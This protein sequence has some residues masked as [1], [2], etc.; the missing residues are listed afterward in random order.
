MPLA[1]LFRPSAEISDAE[2]ARVFALISGP[3]VSDTPPAP[4]FRAPALRIQQGSAREP[5]HAVPGSPVRCWIDGRVFDVARAA[6][7]HGFPEAATASA[8]L[9]QAW[10]RGRLDQVLPDLNGDFFAALHDER[11]GKLVLIADR[12]GLR[13]VYFRARAPEFFFCSRLRGFLGLANFSPRIAEETAACF[14]DLGHLAGD[15][16]WFEGVNLLPP[17]TWLEV[18]LNA[19]SPPRLRRYWTWQAI[20]PLNLEL[21]EAVE[22]FSRLLRQA[23]SRR[24][25]PGEKVSVLLSGGLDSRALLGCV[26]PASLGGTATFGQP[27]C[28]DVVYAERVARIYGSDHA[29]FP[30]TPENWDRGRFHAVWKCDGMSSPADLSSSQFSGEMAALGAA[31]M[32]GFAGDLVAG[33]SYLK[34]GFLNTAA[35]A[36]FAA[37]SYGEQ[38]RWTD[39]GDD[40]ARGPHTDPFVLANRVRRLT[41]AGNLE[42]DDRVEQRKPF[43]DVDLLDFLYAL[44]DEYRWKGKLYHRA[45]LRMRPDL[46]GGVP[47]QKTGLP[48]SAGEGPLGWARA[49]RIRLWEKLG[50]NRMPGEFQ[51]FPRWLAASAPRYAALLGNK[52]A[53]WPGFVDEGRR[54]N[55]DWKNRLAGGNVRTLLHAIGLEVWLQQVFNGRYRDPGASA[56]EA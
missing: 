19:G 23:V 33:G 35:D 38:A 34:A 1:G 56:T 8:L 32:N 48:L 25:F 6:R 20:R 54:E 21:P 46:F 41:V 10:E 26:P 17:A 37:R 22:E 24:I 30:L 53:L 40:Y 42:I 16:T 29:T 28:R 3:V 50:W 12:L 31:N 11:S 13:P 15:L 2:F 45:L 4:P 27:G 18:D 52:D 47:W 55:F 44:P 51:D 49:K 36:A 5:A 43:M 9:A 14:L 7:R 39:P